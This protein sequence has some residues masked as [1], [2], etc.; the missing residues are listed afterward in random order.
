MCA[1]S[2][3]IYLSCLKLRV[4]TSLHTSWNAN[5]NSWWANSTTD[6]A[7]KLPS[8]HFIHNF[9]P[10]SW[11]TLLCCSTPGL[12]HTLTTN[13]Y[14][15]L[16]VEWSVAETKDRDLQ[17]TGNIWLKINKSRGLVVH[18]RKVTKAIMIRHFLFLASCAGFYSCDM[19]M[20][21]KHQCTCES[22]ANV[23]SLCTHVKYM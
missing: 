23:L 2:P 5:V 15:T 20:K 22:S 18:G 12:H 7:D 4:V 3:G 1:Q 8:K 16:C 14:D 10:F 21:F 13:L 9:P 6:K 11:Q 17:I 19:E